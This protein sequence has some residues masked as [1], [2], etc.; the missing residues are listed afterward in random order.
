[1][2]FISGLLC[3][4]ASRLAWPVRTLE[5]D[6]DPGL[7]PSGLRWT[8][9]VSAT[10]PIVSTP[11]RLLELLLPLVPSGLGVGT[12]RAAMGWPTV[13]ACPEL[14]QVFALSSCVPANLSVPGKLGQF[15]HWVE[16]PSLVLSLCSAHTLL[17]CPFV[18]ISSNDTTLCLPSVSS[19]G[20]G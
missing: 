16:T 3:S 5:G 14:S 15:S 9:G 7:L 13:L 12:H 2:A 1:M 4:L 8:G 11:S 20:P 6:A 18:T 17:C 19:W 10:A